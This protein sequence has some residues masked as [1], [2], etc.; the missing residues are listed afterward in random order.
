MPIAR[1]RS[2]R[3]LAAMA[4]ALLRLV[5]LIALLVMPVGMATAPAM[6]QPVAAGEEAHC[7]DHQQPADSP[8]AQ[9]VHCTG[10]SA[11]PAMEV[12]AAVSRPLP[13]APV[14]ISLVDPLSEIEPELAT[15][16]P[17]LS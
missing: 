16:P 13:Q 10:C 15:P 1:S 2:D 17:K 11:L 7:G 12:P 4:S 14:L 5:T 3:Y 8:P 9:Q 6:A